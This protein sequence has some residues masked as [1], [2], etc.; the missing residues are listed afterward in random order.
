MPGPKLN[1][2]RRFPDANHQPFHKAQQRI[3]FAQ[4]RQEEYD[5]LTIAQKIERLDN[6]LGKGV[7]AVKQRA[8]LAAALQARQ[9]KK[10]AIATAI[11]KAKKDGLYDVMEHR[12]SEVL[13]DLTKDPKKDNSNKK[14]MKGAK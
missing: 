3:D 14:Y 2:R 13:A 1:N 11:D 7:G 10:E 6:K 4:D 12:T 5:A 8:R 9:E